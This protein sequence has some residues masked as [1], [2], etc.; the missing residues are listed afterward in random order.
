MRKLVLLACVFLVSAVV[1][2]SQSG[3]VAGEWRGIWTNPEG[4]VYTAKMI[5]ET[6]PGC[7][8]CAAKGEGSVTGKIEWSLRKAGAHTPDMADRMG[9]VSKELVKGEMRGEGLLVL[10]G[11]D[12]DDPNNIKP[13]DQYR[14]AL[15]DNG[16]VLGGIS[17]NGGTWTGQ[18][19][20]VR[21]Q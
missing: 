10:N 15:S 2:S 17:L 13:L 3:S 1:C 11:Y 20:A 8:T 21:V 9:T 12:R 14:L 5:L 6:G 7:K 19:I 16:K 4:N 18:L